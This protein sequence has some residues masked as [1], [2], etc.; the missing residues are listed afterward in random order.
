M[1]SKSWQP[2]E[3]YGSNWFVFAKAHSPGWVPLAL[4]CFFFCV[5]F[6]GHRFFQKVTGEP[7]GGLTGGTKVSHSMALRH[8]AAE[9]PFGAGRPEGAERFSS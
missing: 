5:F 3:L 9:G 4:D 2:V 6:P 7:K 1:K 8:Q